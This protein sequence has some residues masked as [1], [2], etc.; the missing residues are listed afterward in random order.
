M[1]P[2][3]DQYMHHKI[4]MEIMMEAG[5]PKVHVGQIVFDLFNRAQSNGEVTFIDT[6]GVT[7]TKAE[8]PKGQTFIERFMISQV[9]TGSRKKGLVGLG[10]R[11]VLFRAYQL[12]PFAMTSFNW[13]LIGDSSA[14]PTI[15]TR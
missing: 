1:K 5:T 7:M 14:N 10:R 8:F 4:W 15:L 6:A 9:P 3:Q 12:R 11:N 13:V 2:N